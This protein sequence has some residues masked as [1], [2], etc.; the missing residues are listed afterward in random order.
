MKLAT[1]SLFML[2]TCY[3]TCQGLPSK[4]PNGSIIWEPLPSLGEFVVEPDLYKTDGNRP[5]TLADMCRGF[6]NFLQPSGF[7]I[8]KSISLP[9]KVKTQYLQI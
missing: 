4:S 5:A 2:V 6:V 1:L 3:N 8:G 7:P 9:H